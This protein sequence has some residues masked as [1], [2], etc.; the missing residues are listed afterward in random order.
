MSLEKVARQMAAKGRNG[1]DMLVHMTR[2]EVAGLQAL[3][4]AH[5]TALTRNPDTGLP[6]AFSLRSLLPALA[7]AAMTY[8]SGGAI[9]PYMS[10]GIMGL[11]TKAT[12]GSWSDAMKAGLG[13]YGGGAFGAGAAESAA[14]SSELA[15]QPAFADATMAQKADALGGVTQEGVA[16]GMSPYASPMKAGLM[17]ASPALLETPKY[18]GPEKLK[19]HI[20]PYELD[21][22]YVEGAPID[23]SERL[24]IRDTWTAG[25]VREAAEGGSMHAGWGPQPDERT[26]SKYT[27]DPSTGQYSQTTKTPIYEMVENTSTPQD[28]TIWYP[29]SRELTGYKEATKTIGGVSQAPQSQPAVGAYRPASAAGIGYVPSQAYGG[30]GGGYRPEA[31]YSPPAAP[32]QKTAAGG[33]IM[34]LAQGGGYD[35]GDYSDGGQLLRGPGDGVSDS[36]PASIGGK[37]PARLAEGEFVIPARVVSELGNGSTEAGAKQLYAMMDRIQ[38]SRSKTVGKGKVAVDSKAHTHLPA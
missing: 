37:R 11:G 30:G 18:T 12:G 31:V 29:Q 35:L 34:Q 33:G 19:S 21:R 9:N 32:T 26:S 4:R 14:A 22:E 2:G 27:Y 25:P 16:T 28:G 3:A 5:G 17:A 36:I 13:A 7:G 10:A 1:D 15:G 6:E 8:F 38:K 20:R 24:Q 23:S